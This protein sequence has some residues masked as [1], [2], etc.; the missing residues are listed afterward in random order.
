[1]PSRAAI[2]FFFFFLNHDLLYVERRAMVMPVRLRA[3]SR[4]TLK[5][6]LS[7]KAVSSRQCGGI[8]E[9]L[10]INI[11]NVFRLEDQ[12]TRDVVVG[13]STSLTQW[14]G[15][16]PNIGKGSLGP[17]VSQRSRHGFQNPPV[18]DVRLDI[19][20]QINMVISPLLRC[21]LFTGLSTTNKNYL[22]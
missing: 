17:S 18:P 22:V 5:E 20:T 11:N 3:A 9:S 16:Y 19:Y 15:R 21:S 13:F 8:V 7:K 10:T 2:P 6:L 12:T 14:C 4:G 1:M